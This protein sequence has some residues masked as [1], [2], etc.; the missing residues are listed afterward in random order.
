MSE[1]GRGIGGFTVTDKD[2]NIYTLWA[3][4]IWTRAT[5]PHLEWNEEKKAWVLPI[6]S[7]EARS[8]DTSTKVQ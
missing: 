8:L 2:G 3:N 4:R 6:T 5:D 7:K 1:L